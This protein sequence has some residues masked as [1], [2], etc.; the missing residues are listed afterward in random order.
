MFYNITFFAIFYFTNHFPK[1]NLIIIIINIE[2]TIIIRKIHNISIDIFLDNQKFEDF[3]IQFIKEF[4][5]VYG[6]FT[7]FRI[8][9][10]LKNK[11]WD[12][13]VLEE[14]FL[15]KVENLNFTKSFDERIWNYWKF[16]IFSATNKEYI[17]SLYKKDNKPDN[18]L[19]TKRP[20]Y[21]NVYV[22][23][24]AYIGYL[25]YNSI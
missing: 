16:K 22:S 11:F 9:N 10:I 8:L 23:F 3:K 19:L 13:Y 6:N 4:T 5:S 18:W 24:K 17:I 2:K 25:K 15:I 1:F 14:E 20:L 21:G 7:H 12:I